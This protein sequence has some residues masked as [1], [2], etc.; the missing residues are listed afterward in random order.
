MRPDRV[1]IDPPGFDYPAR[2]AQAI[3]Q[4]FIQALISKSAIEALN[5]GVLSWLSWRDIVPFQIN[6]L[7]PF[8]DR[9]TGQ[10]STIIGD[11]HLRFAALLDQAV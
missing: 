2:I 1:V 10:F 6:L 9:M 4:M 5:K 8:Q 7:D 3:E 11:D